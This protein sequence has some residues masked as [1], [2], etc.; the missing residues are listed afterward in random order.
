MHGKVALVVGGAG[1]FGRVVA[2]AFR[3][4]EYRVALADIDLRRLR[5]VSDSLGKGISY[6]RVDL[7]KEQSV[8]HMVKKVVKEMG[9][10]DLLFLGHGVTAGRTMMQDTTLGEWEFVLRTNLTGSFLCM[11]P[12]VKIMTKQ[13]SGC[14]ISLSTGREGRK[15][16][17]PYISSKWGLDGL[18]AST[19]KEVRERNIG[20]YA[21]NPGGYAATKFHDNSY[22]LMKFKNH[23]PDEVR[24][25]RTKAVKPEVIVPLCLYLAEDRSLELTG[26]TMSAIKWNVRQGLDRNTWLGS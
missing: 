3:E 16:S 9:R 2:E 22:R 5:V 7:T 4:R 13:K 6:F 19:A 23:I 14:I 25:A 1:G 8:G 18:V 20:V 17:S 15:C 11:K 24:L 26:R 10:I 12:V 21:V